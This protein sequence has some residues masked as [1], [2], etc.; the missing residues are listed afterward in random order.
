MNQYSQQPAQFQ[1]GQQQFS[2]ASQNFQPTGF[3]QSHY[4]GQLSYPTFGRE[5]ASIVSPSFNNAGSQHSSNGYQQHAAPAIQSYTQPA[6]SNH[7]Y[8]SHGPVQSHASSPATAFGDVGPV[9]ARYGYQAGPDQQ[10]Q[11]GFSQQYGQQSYSQP[12]QYSQQSFGQAG[13]QSHGPVHSNTSINPVYQATNAYE[14]A[15]PVIARY[16]Y[17][18]SSAQSNS[19]YSR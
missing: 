16:G 15:G 11:Q 5:S 6:V 10:Q 19:Q 4:Q 1:G 7:A 14:Q 8:Q 3:V 9:I 12:A 17:Q 2:N 13:Y 18:S